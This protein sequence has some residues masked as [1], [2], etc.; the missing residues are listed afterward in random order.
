MNNLIK[1]I[2]EGEEIEQIMEYAV[3]DIYKNGS[4]SIT[5]MEVLC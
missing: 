3:S 2:I 1:K 4:D 5:N